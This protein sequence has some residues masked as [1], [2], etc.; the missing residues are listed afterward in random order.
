MGTVW[1]QKDL[2]SISAQISC[3]NLLV[4]GF[5]ALSY[6]V[7]QKELT[8]FYHTVLKVECELSY[9]DFGMYLKKNA[10]RKICVSG[11]VGG[12]VPY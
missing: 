2:R 10:F 9:T 11:T 1:D 3:Q 8:I 7:W 5:K 4:A 6:A 12:R